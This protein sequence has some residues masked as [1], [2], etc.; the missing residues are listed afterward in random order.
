MRHKILSTI[1][2]V[3][4]ICG[5][6]RTVAV[7]FIILLV[8]S[9]NP[10]LTTYTFIYNDKGPN[11]EIA[12]RMEILLEETYYNT[13]IVLMKGEGTNQNLDSLKTAQVDFA[14]VENYVNY[15]EGINSVFSIYSEVLHIFYVAD[16]TITSFKEIVYD[17]PIYIGIEESPTYN[18]MMDLFDFYGVDTSRINVTFQMDQAEVVV[19]LSNLLSEEMLQ[20]FRGFRL[21][22]FDT[23]QNVG[24]YS[25]VEGISLKYPRLSPFVIPKDS[26]RELSSTPLVT[27]SVDLIMMVSSGVGEVPVNDFVKT[28]LRNRQAFTGID[29][30]LYNGMREDFNQSKLN[31]PLH[32]GARSYLARDEPSFLE[33]YA[34]LAGVILSLIIATWSGLVSLAK[35]QAQKKKDRIDE[36]YADLITIKNH[37]PMLKKPVEAIER[38]KHVKTS[39]NKAFELLIAE[40]LVANESFRI[41]MELSKETI[42]ELRSKLKAL[43]SMNSRV[44]V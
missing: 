33:R 42:L 10:T 41:Y 15:T 3:L 28:M 18:L 34:E 11:Q 9:C 40:E 30:L 29:P 4:V 32:E 22:S 25:T 37:I 31:I 43:K 19:V 36:F 6:N 12:E 7:V 23:E 21:F 2:N 17:K 14:M 44:S 5:M 39:Q 8:T 20:Q 13:D 27:L 35:W 26:Y 24:N 1:F 38:I 16:K